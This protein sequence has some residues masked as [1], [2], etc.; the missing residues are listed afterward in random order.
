[1]SLAMAQGVRAGA[2]GDGSTRARALGVPPPQ[3]ASIK[4]TQGKHRAFAPN[5]PVPS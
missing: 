3:A 1:M 4:T 2:G 5:D